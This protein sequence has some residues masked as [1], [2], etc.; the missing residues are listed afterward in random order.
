MFAEC[1]ECYVARVTAYK[2]TI[3]GQQV[4]QRY[5]QS[6]LGKLKKKRY[7]E[8]SPE[9]LIAH[10]AVHAAV[11]YGKLVRGSCEVCGGVAE[12]HHADY[13]RPL[14]V[15]WLCLVHHRAEHE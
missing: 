14:E 1:R 10:S 13:S 11:R 15:R 2:Q 7:Y 6:P 12:A 8:K 4:E 3:A 9:K 5:R